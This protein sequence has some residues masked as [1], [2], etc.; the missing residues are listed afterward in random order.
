MTN[1]TIDELFWN[2]ATLRIRASHH[3]YYI[4]I[5]ILCVCMYMSTRWSG[6]CNTAGYFI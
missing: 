2:D 4:I 3:R 1:T 5:T 6:I